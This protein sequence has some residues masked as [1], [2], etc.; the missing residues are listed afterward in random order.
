MT[1]TALRKGCDREKRHERNVWRKEN[2]EKENSARMHI[3]GGM[4]EEK[5]YSIGDW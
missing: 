4:G 3:P 5:A 1:G 2:V